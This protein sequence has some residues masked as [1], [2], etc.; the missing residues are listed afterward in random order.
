V[1][2]YRM[3]ATISGVESFDPIVNELMSMAPKANLVK[4][5]FFRNSGTTLP[6]REC[7]TIRTNLVDIIHGMSHNRAMVLLTFLLTVL[8]ISTKAATL[9]AY[10]GQYILPLGTRN[11]Y[12]LDIRQDQGTLTGTFSRPRR[13]SFSST[14]FS[15]LS[16]E[17][18]AETIVSAT[19]EGDHLHLVVANPS[20]PSDTDIY[21]LTL[22]PSDHAT[23][24]VAIDHGPQWTL[25]RVPTSPKLTVATDWEPHRTY[26]LDDTSQSNPEMERIF[27]ED[28]KPRLAT[29]NVS[30]I[31]WKNVSQQDALRRQQVN[32]LLTQDALHTG[33]D[34]EAAAFIFQH[35]DKSDDYLLAHTLAMIAVARGQ[36]SA[37]WIA[38][39]SFDRYLNAIQQPQVFGTQYYNKPGGWTQQPYNRTL[40][41][42][43]L[44]AKLNV[45]SQADQ[46]RQL[47][48]FEKA[49]KH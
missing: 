45:G 20:K 40:I 16:P 23:L 31:D 4:I 41:S 28:Q 1:I 18:V 13:S 35:G 32:D 43:Q 5:P 34:F 46:Q 33:R 47:E 9:E 48:E 44:R 37:I 42:D 17:V 19:L 11:L 25:K 15:N 8:S 10:V 49:N 39:A 21:N 22:L 27:Q 36:S 30:K 7:A 26:F 6:A 12:V 2:P 24:Q 38:T 29:Q 14:F 3:I